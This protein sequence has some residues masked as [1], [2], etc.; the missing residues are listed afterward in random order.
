MR[1]I[2]ITLALLV[3]ASITTGVALAQSPHYK[4]GPSC[5]D[6]G[7][8]ATCTGTVAGLGNATVTI[9]LEFP[10]A[11]GTTI[12]SNPG[13]Q[14]VPGQNPATPAPVSGSASVSNIKNGTLSFTVTTNPPTNPTPQAAGCP[15]GNW[16]ATFS[17]ITFGS[18][19]LTL[20]Q[21]GVEVLT[22]NVSL[23]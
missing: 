10:N 9:D 1:R 20:F 19:T 5:V 23:P 14:Q 18:G 16:S 13:G 6:N 4:K 12:C 21:G 17:N 15:N 11:T 3:M 7:L 22:T 8:T 2:S